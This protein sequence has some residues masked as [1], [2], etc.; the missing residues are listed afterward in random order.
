MLDEGLEKYTSKVCIPKSNTMYHMYILDASKCVHVVHSIGFKSVLILGIH[1]SLSLSLS[2]W[3][4]SMIGENRQFVTNEL[5][6]FQ[7]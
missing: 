2:L 4:P 3:S 7:K 1:T 5:V 6:E